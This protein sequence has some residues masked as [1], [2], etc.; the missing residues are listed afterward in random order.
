MQTIE[1]GG[2]ILSH[3]QLQEKIQ[4][5]DIK[6]MIESNRLEKMIDDAIKVDVV[7]PTKSDARLRE[8][9]FYLD[10]KMHRIVDMSMDLEIKAE[11][12]C[13]MK[14]KEIND[15]MKQWDDIFHKKD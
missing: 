9:L 14:C 10:Y 1:V 3:T 15:W 6:S 2:K 7:N 8:S 11:G 5:D 12:L 13:S 4:D